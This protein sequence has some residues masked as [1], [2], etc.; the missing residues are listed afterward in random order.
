MGSILKKRGAEIRLKAKPT[1][2]FSG[3]KADFA[4]LIDF[5]DAANAAFAGPEYQAIVS[6]RGL[7][8]ERVNIVILG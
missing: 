7:A 3:S 6:I 4:M 1:A 8:F 5:P 2:Y